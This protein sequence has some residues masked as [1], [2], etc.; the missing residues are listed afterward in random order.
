MTLLYLVA[1]WIAGVFLGASLGGPDYAWA[2]LGLAGF[3][4]AGVIRRRPRRALGSP[5]FN[6]FF[7]YKV[8]NRKFRSGL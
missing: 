8:L 6:R 3:A 2:A 4:A 5:I 1:S 7:F